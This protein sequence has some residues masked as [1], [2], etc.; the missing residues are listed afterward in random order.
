[1]IKIGEIIPITMVPYAKKARIVEIRGGHGFQRKMRVMG[2]REGKILRVVTK[3]PLHG[4][5]TIET[6]GSQVTIGMGMAKRI[7]VEVIE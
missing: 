5:L 6:G 4:P 7:L 1:M 3:Q 2:L